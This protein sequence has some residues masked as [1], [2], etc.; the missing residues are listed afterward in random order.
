M[1]VLKC[2]DIEYKLNIPDFY[3][4]CSIPISTKACE[5]GIR[6]SLEERSNHLGVVIQNHHNA[7]DDAITCANIVIATITK[8]KKRTFNSFLTVYS[9]LNIKK[10]SELKHRSYFGKK[11]TAKQV[12]INSIERVDLK[13]LKPTIDTIN[14]NHPFYGKTFV[15]TGKLDNYTKKDAMQEVVNL[16]GVVLKEKLMS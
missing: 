15:F 5:K 3:Y 8:C 6:R 14:T 12:A 13:S 7:L 16:G 9:S 4:M 2:L 10:Y 11:K 1:S